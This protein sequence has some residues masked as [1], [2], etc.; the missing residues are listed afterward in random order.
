MFPSPSSAFRPA[1]LDRRDS[2]KEDRLAVSRLPR[3][4]RE[5]ARRSLRLE[6]AR[7]ARGK[8]PGLY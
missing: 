1:R 8:K 4:D 3:K 2:S 6:A 5:E 7:S